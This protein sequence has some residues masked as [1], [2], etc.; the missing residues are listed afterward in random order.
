MSSIRPPSPRTRSGMSTASFPIIRRVEPPDFFEEAPAPG[1]PTP[2]GYLRPA[3]GGVWAAGE[4]VT[5]IAGL[6]LALSPLMDW[7]TGHGPGSQ[8]AVIGWHTG[9]LGKLVLILGI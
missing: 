2:T 3:A 8:I 6:V 9:V 7:Y 5:G 4:R 1:A